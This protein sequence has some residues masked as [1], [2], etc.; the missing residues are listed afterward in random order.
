MVQSEQPTDRTRFTNLSSVNFDADISVAKSALGISTIRFIGLLNNNSGPDDTFSII[1]SA[2]SSSI[3]SP[4]YS[5]GS[6]PCWPSADISDKPRMHSFVF[7][8]AGIS[9]SYFR[10]T[11]NSTA[12]RRVADT[13]SGFRTVDYFEIGNLLISDGITSGQVLTG[14]SGIKRGSLSEGQDEESRQ[15]I[16]EGGQTF[17]RVRPKPEIKTFSLM[18]KGP[19]ADQEYRSGLAKIKRYCGV[20]RSVLFC[21]D[22]NA[23]DF[24]LD[25]MIY[26]LFQGWQD[27]SRPQS[28]YYEILVKIKE[29]L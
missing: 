1:G 28:Q 15:V 2:D 20:S 7:I 11:I 19:K 24:I 17:S 13:A 5:S 26:G 21:D 25:R 10:F 4:S 27:L 16:S 3:G 23:D 14:V 9:E 29:L 22:M 18:F 8:P 12:P 6:L